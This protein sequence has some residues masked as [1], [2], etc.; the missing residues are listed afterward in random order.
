M[1]TEAI[2]APAP[3]AVD[4]DIPGAN[5]KP[6]G[7]HSPP[8]S[9]NAMDADGSDSELSD[10]DEVAVKLGGA[11]GAKLRDELQAE[12]KDEPKDHPRNEPKDETAPKAH[13]EAEDIGEILPDHWSGS[14]PVFKPTMKQFEDF[15]LFVCW[16]TPV[17][18]SPSSQV[19]LTTGV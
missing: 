2:G 17:S 14:V 18:W 8:D 5:S 11:L 15:K 9:N 19:P 1:S 10:L 13:P 12:F 16:R 4:V 3:L 7:L 6:T